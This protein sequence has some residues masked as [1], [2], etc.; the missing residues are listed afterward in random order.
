MD[1]CD[2]TSFENLENKTKQRGKGVTHSLNTSPLIISH[3][4]SC[5]E[6]C[7]PLDGEQSA[8]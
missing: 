2:K 5:H 8:V 7:K 6:N 4:S 1:N 3:S